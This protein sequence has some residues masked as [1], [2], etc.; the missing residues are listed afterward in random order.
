MMLGAHL[1]VQCSIAGEGR[2][3]AIEHILISLKKSAMSLL[4][5]A[6]M[7]SLLLRPRQ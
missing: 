1:V 3:A 2:G 7:L 4:Q 5:Q 6:G